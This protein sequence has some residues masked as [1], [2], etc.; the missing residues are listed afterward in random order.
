MIQCLHFPIF[1]WPRWALTYIPCECGSIDLSIDPCEF[2]L[3]LSHMLPLR[4]RPGGFLVPDPGGGFLVPDPTEQ[5][6]PQQIDPTK[7]MI[8]RQPQSPP[9]IH[10]LQ[11]AEQM[12][13]STGAQL[14]M[15]G[16]TGA[17]MQMV[18]AQM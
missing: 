2:D 1:S 8:P 10:I 15:V 16:S 7:Q 13:G 17:P 5:M 18:P 14:Q 4:L 12:T 9:P 3:R 11:P 6:I